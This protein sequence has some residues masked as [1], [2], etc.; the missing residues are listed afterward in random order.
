[1]VRAI[2]FIID[3]QHTVDERKTLKRTIVTATEKK[4]QPNDE[5][6][7]THIMITNVCWMIERIIQPSNNITNI[8]S[9]YIVCKI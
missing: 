6:G 5:L 2:R 4:H 9:H 7:K 1:M 3:S 8:L